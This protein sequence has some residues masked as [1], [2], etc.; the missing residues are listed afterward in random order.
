MRMAVQPINALK[1]V[2]PGDK[3]F[4]LGQ[5]SKKI[6]FSRRVPALFRYLFYIGQQNQ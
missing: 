3:L 1:L 5:E 2:A 6:F 4:V